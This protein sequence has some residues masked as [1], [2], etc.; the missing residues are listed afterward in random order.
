MS[1]FEEKTEAS[2]IKKV[3]EN[4][5]VLIKE[6]YQ[7]YE[8]LKKSGNEDIGKR[9]AYEGW[10]I[11]KISSLQVTVLELHKQIQKLNI[12]LANLNKR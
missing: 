1:L 10:A 11:Q 6:F 8:D 5:E 12:Q 9:T 7:H 2:M 3:D 4:T